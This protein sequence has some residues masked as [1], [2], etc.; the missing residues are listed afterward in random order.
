[1]EG[2]RRRDVERTTRVKN[3]RPLREGGENRSFLSPGKH[4]FDN[5]KR[6]AQVTGGESFVSETNVTL[7]L[8]EV[9]T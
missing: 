1:M 9:L 6:L 4:M 8:L 3:A 2:K 5:Q 7:E